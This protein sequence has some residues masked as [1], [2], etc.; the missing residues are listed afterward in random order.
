MTR[1]AVTLQ[2]LADVRHHQ[3]AALSRFARRV[4]LHARIVARRLFL[5][6]VQP[7]TEVGVGKVVSDQPHGLHFV[8]LMDVRCTVVAHYMTGY[9]AAPGEL[10]RDLE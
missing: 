10:V 3:G 1:V 2:T 8:A 4:A 6:Q 7:M 9:A 5:D